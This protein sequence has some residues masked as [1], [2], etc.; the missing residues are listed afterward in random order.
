MQV[1][2]VKDLKERI[3]KLLDNDEVGG[4]S[5]I[6][7]CDSVSG[8]KTHFWFEVLTFAQTYCT[9]PLNSMLW[10]WKQKPLGDK[11]LTET[12]SSIQ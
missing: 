8:G 11:H 7:R 1:Y 3:K 6:E 4:Q 2:D 12:C 5:D 9:V 10:P